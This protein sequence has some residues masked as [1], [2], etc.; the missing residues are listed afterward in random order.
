VTWVVVQLITHVVLAPVLAPGSCAASSGDVVEPSD[1]P[2][3]TKHADWQVAACELQVIM[4]LVVVELCA[5]ATSAHAVA[6]AAAKI[7][8]THR[9][10]AGL[11]SRP[12]L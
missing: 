9:I 11:P 7:I 2:A 4:Q 8:A 6:S 12:T 1:G 10:T 5:D 3:G